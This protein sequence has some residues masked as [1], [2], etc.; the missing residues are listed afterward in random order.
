MTFELLPCKTFTKLMCSTRLD[1]PI[2]T[3]QDFFCLGLKML[4]C[5]YIF[6]GA[7]VFICA[8][9]RKSGQREV[10]H[11]CTRAKDNHR[12]ITC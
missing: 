9:V 7:Q 5:R 3:T 4:Q 11:G 6:L 1:T 8:L 2:Y 12:D 10:L